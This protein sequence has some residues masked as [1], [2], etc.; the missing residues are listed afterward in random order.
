VRTSQTSSSRDIFAG[1]DARVD[2]FC[3]I[4]P[5]HLPGRLRAANR[6]ADD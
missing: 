4:R 2:L 5:Q 3:C 6:V 1:A